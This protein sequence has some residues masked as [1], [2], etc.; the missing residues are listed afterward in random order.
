MKILDYILKFGFMYMISICMLTV[1]GPWLIETGNTS[2]ISK[3]RFEN[4]VELTLDNAFDSDKYLKVSTVSE[5]NNKYEVNFYMPEGGHKKVLA[6]LI[7]KK[8]IKEPDSLVLPV[9]I[10]SKDLKQFVDSK[11]YGESGQLIALKVDNQ[12][13][14]G[15]N[16][17]IIKRLIFYFFGGVTMIVGF[18]SLIFTSVVMVD[19]IK[20]YKEKGSFPDLPN[21]VESKLNGIKYLFGGFKSDKKKDS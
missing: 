12:Y 2:I 10:G 5:K 6:I 18:L 9:S 14:I 4:V 7:E 13:L 1:M 17:S 19:N 8:M 3:D 11:V 20:I 21:S 15:K 16:P